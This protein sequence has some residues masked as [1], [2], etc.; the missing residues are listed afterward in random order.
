MHAPTLSSDER[1]AIGQNR[2]FSTLSPSL[3]HDILRQARAWRLPG[4]GLIAERGE[5]P[6]DWM[7]VAKGEVR[8]SSIPHGTQRQT[9]SYMGPGR[10]FGD[11]ALCDGGPNTHDAHAH[12]DTTLLCVPALAFQGLL[13]TH[14]E[15]ALALARLHAHQLREVFARLEDLRTLA[16]KQ[17]LAKLLLRIHRAR[18][19]ADDVG[20]MPEVH[21]ELDRGQDDLASWLGAS[22]Q[23]TNQELKALER[24]NVIRIERRGLVIRDRG[25]LRQLLD[26]VRP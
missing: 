20:G 2:W 7:A 25:G 15:L 22:R 10:W 18:S 4:G 13:Q 16:L 24:D 1:L 5:A 8:I 14:P 3:R 17:R 19:T 6:Q 9:L 12:G 26:T 23:R 11:V 21:L